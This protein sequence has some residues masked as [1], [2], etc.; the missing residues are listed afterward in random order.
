MKIVWPLLIWVVLIVVTNWYLNFVAFL[1][2]CGMSERKSCIRSWLKLLSLYSVVLMNM[3][4]RCDIM[5]FWM[6]DSLCVFKRLLEIGLLACVEVDYCLRWTSWTIELC[7][8]RSTHKNSDFYVSWNRERYKLLKSS[9]LD[10]LSIEKV[11]D[12]Q[13][14]LL[15]FYFLFVAIFRIFR[16]LSTQLPI[17]QI[18]VE[19]RLAST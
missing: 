2:I 1:M 10:L 12:F 14:K 5:Q 17:D 8:Q 13:T 18:A 9:A 4:R 3:L 19:H 16:K 7:H 11:T 6:F 15:S